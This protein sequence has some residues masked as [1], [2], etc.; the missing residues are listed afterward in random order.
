[1]IKV[2]VTTKDGTVQNFE[3]QTMTEA[4]A[5]FVFDF[6]SVYTEVHF[7]NIEEE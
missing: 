4:I 1:M 2:T 3:T 5:R 6:F 7:E